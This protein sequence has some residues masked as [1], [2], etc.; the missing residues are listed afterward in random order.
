MTE[1][2][3]G[4][5]NRIKDILW[6]NI[7]TPIFPSV[8]DL[9]ITFHILHHEGRQPWHLGWLHPERRIEHFVAYLATQGFYNHFVAWVDD[10]QVFSLRRK[11]GFEFQYQLRIFNDGEVCGHYEKTPEA[12]P[13]GHFSEEFFKPRTEDFLKWLGDW[14]VDTPSNQETKTISQIAPATSREFPTNG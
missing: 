14:I 12:S 5:L 9:L 8:R 11:D 4:F 1:E 6:R 2:K 7:I 3:L 13:I 10:D